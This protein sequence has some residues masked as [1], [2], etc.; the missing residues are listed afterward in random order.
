MINVLVNLHGQVNP[1][2]VR[3][4]LHKLRNVFVVLAMIVLESLH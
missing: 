2:F 3:Q 4:L 1:Q